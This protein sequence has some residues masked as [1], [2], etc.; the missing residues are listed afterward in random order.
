MSDDLP[1]PAPELPGQLP[2]PGAI[3][4]CSD[5]SCP[6]SAVWQL[7][8]IDAPD[9]VLYLCDDHVPLVPAVEGSTWGIG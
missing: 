1:V 3:I 7:R 8:P 2:L 4:D 9:V 6:R 5:P